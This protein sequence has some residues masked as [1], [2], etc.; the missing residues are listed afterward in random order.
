M[1]LNKEYKKAIKEAVQSR[2]SDAKIYLFGS[3]VD[4]AKKGG[5]IDL[6]V[7]VDKKP[8]FLDKPQILAE[9]KKKIKEQ[10]IDLVFNY[11]NKKEEL[12]DKKAKQNGVLL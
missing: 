8:H 6:Y 10:K 3:R 4:D 1:R 7:E 2:F 12:I 11:P 5:D 9:I